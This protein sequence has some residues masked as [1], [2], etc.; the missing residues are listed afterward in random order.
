MPAR[1]ARLLLFSTETP[2]GGS[3]GSVAVAVGVGVGV[4]GAINVDA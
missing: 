4:A 3:G 1:N 2:F